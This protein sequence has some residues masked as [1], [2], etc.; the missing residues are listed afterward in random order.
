MQGRIF[1][2][3]HHFVTKLSLETM[4]YSQ[5]VI[6]FNPASK[7]S[8]DPHFALHQTVLPFTF[9]GKARPFS[10]GQFSLTIQDSIVECSLE[11][12]LVVVS[13]HPFTMRKTLS[14][15]LASV[16]TFSYSVSYFLFVLF[17]LD[18]QLT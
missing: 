11:H 7:V 2:R 1:S 14:I 5:M 17:Q 16:P 4:R 18:L 9:N 12:I 10:L 15:S 6:T 8:L 13:K 3:C